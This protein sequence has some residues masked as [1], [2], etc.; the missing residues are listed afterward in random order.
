MMSKKKS[1]MVNHPPHY[2]KGKYEVLD[3]I[4]DQLGQGYEPYLKGNILKYILRYEF[5]N[6]VE[7]LNSYLNIYFKIFPFK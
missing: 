1:D 2:N 7:D 6:G 4:E 5:K 3:I